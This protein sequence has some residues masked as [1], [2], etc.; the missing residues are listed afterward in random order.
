MVS[1]LHLQGGLSGGLGGGG[2][3]RRERTLRGTHSGSGLGQKAD[4][5]KSQGIPKIPPSPVLS[6]IAPFYR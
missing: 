4:L 2:V 3:R 5:Q 1:S 6:G